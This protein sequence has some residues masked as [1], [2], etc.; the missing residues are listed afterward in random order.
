MLAEGSRLRGISRGELASRTGVNGETIRYFERVG[1]IAAPS[2]T[3]GGH[4]I[5][6]EEHVRALGFIRRARELGFTPDEVRAIVHLGDSS[7]A[8][9][10]EVRDIAQRH[11][12]HV[13]IKI[14]DLV[15]IE[16]LLA[17]TIE[18][19]S[20]GRGPACPVVDLIEDGGARPPAVASEPRR[21]DRGPA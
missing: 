14:A 1:L 19:C 10:G 16:R 4:R 17:S 6:D 2:R 20:G 9:C 13:R 21:D 3:A 5:Y 8:S 12:D 15:S 7:T 11:L 18:R